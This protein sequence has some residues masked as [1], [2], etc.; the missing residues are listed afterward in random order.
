MSPPLGPKRS[1]QTHLRIHSFSAAPVTQNQEDLF[2]LAKLGEVASINIE[3]FLSYGPEVSGWT[4]LTSELISAACSPLAA[5]SIRLRAAEVLVRIVLES[6]AASLPLPDEE[7]SVVQLRLLDAYSRALRQLRSCEQEITVS[8]HATDIDVHKIILEGLKSILEQCGESFISGW[9]IT[10]E[11]I[12]SV[13]T[14]KTLEDEHHNKT[15]VATI[16]PRLIR[17][18]F[19]SLQLICSDFLSSLPNS[20]FLILV[21]TLYNFCSQNDDL[22]ISLTV[23][24]DLEELANRVLT[25]LDRYLLLGALRLHFRP[26]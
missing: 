11:I 21:D 22:N 18:S 9:D 14:D 7:R 16:S 12:G 4:I 15:K 17:S 25:R 10:F 24:R 13:F 6:A 19:N 5:S 20:C 2:A 3:R 8:T 1:T 23:S 26:E